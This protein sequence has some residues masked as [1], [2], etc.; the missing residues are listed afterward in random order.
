MAKKK[1][2][3]SVS[4]K[5][6]PDADMWVYHK[7]N[8]VSGYGGLFVMRSGGLGLMCTAQPTDRTW[9]NLRNIEARDGWIYF[10][11]TEDHSVFDE[12]SREYSRYSDEVKYK[13]KPNG[14]DLMAVDRSIA[15]LSSSN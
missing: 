15:Y 13:I 12:E 4:A 9:S 10:E 11:V 2:K 14:K 1:R 3:P 5:K 7:N 8:I 6:R